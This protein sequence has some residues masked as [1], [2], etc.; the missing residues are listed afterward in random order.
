M[1]DLA[2]QGNWA[3]I[4]D[5][6][7]LAR[8][9]D[10]LAVALAVSLPWST[11][12][13]GIFAVLWLIALIPTLEPAALR[14]VLTTPAGGLPVLL[15]AFGAAGMLWA[16]VSFAERLD[17]LASFHKLLCI[18]LLM[19]QFRRSERARWVLGGF[20]ASCILLLVISFGL[21]VYQAVVGQFQIVPGILVKDYISQ[22]TMFTVCVFVV[23]EVA[24]LAWLEGRRPLA[25]GY[26]LLSLLF[27]ANILLVT[28]NRTIVLL[29]PILLLLFGV[30]R[31]GWRTAA[32][33][34]LAGTILGALAWPIS[35]LMQHRIG[36]F[37]DELSRYQEN[38]GSS[39]GERLEFWKKS[40]GFVA[41]APVFGHGT[42]SIPSLFR[43]AAAGQSGIAALASTNPHNQVLAVAVQLGLAGTAVLLA[44]WLAHLWLFRG[45]GIAAWVGL[46]VVAQNLISAPVHSHL[47]DFTQGWLYVVGV[48]I[49]GGA[50]LRNI[51]SQPAA[52]A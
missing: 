47:F 3:K 42:G 13:T 4:F 37:Y 30:M 51:A 36:Q 18:P 35:P 22:G 32:A 12:A 14:R 48:G 24:R 44:M 29:I 8:T 5:R 50:S 25:V 20:L 23:A 41:S 16:D 31:F 46:V 34:L 43:Q 27:F 45:G 40:V 38:I 33:M 39:A 1:A 15:W 9:A 49:A 52:T 6:A 7:R 10:G 21:V 17:G 26:G 2:E 11:S 28:F 19:A